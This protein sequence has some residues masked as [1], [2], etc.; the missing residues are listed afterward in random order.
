VVQVLLGAAFAMGGAM[1]V[2]TPVPELYEAM[3]WARDMP[4]GLVRF[5]GLAEV[6]G[7]LGLVLPSATRVRPTLTVWAAIGLVVVMVLAALFHV[8]RGEYSALGING[9]LAGLAA[10][11][12]WGRARKAP[13]ASR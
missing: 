9:V 10:F 5:I 1:K 13:I 4:V 3:D 11:V 7:A 8:G 2:L 12:A 6:A